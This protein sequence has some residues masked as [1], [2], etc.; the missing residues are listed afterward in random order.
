MA[1]CRVDNPAVALSARFPKDVYPNLKQL[2]GL[3]K[4]SDIVKEYGSRYPELQLEESAETGALGFKSNSFIDTEA[5]FTLEE[6]LAMELKNIKSNAENMAGKGHTVEDAVIT[7]PPFFTAQERQAV[8]TAVELAGFRLLSLLSDGLAVGLNYATSR[9][10]PVVNEGGKPEV[11]LVYD[12]G[13]GSASATVLKFQGKTVKDVGKF[14]K[15]IQEVHVVGSSWDRT[16]GGDSLNR[17][18]LD[19]MLAK[20]T[21]QPATKHLSVTQVQVQGH[22]RTMSKL[23]KEAQRVRQVLSANTE[24]HASFEGLYSEDLNFKYKLSRSEFESLASGHQ[25]RVQAPIQKALDMA[26]LKLEE[27]D[28]VILHGGA[29][30]TPFIQKE[31]EGLVGKGKLRTNVNSD[32]AA[33]L[34]A[35]FRSATISPSFRVKEIRPFDIA[36]YPIVAS[37][38][39]DGK[40]KQQKLFVPT[41]TIGPE[42]QI[43]FKTGKDFAFALSQQVTPGSS[44]VISNFQTQNLT[45]SIKS[46]VSHGCVAS[47]INPKFGIRLSPLNGLPEVVSG[48]VSCETQEPEKK[49]VVDGM[50]DFLGFGSKKD[51]QKPLKADEVESSST[52]TSSS[53][54]SPSES[55]SSSESA[56]SSKAA[57]KPKEPK[58]KAITIPLSISVEPVNAS[59]IKSSNL[60]RIKDRITAFDASDRARDLRAESLNTLE[61][62]TYK[63][64]ETL[65]ED[66]FILAST[67]SQR[68]E[69]SKSSGATSAWLYEDG[70]DAPQDVLKEK[71]DQLR[72]LVNPIKTRVSEEKN[73]PEALKKLEDSLKQAESMAGVIRSMLNESTASISFASEASA[74]EAASSSAAASSSETTSST[75]KDDFEDL[76]E[77]S[78]SSPATS[79]TTSTPEP[80]PPLF[81]ENDL[82]LVEDKREDVQ[83]WLN[84]K[85]AKQQKLG[86]TDDPVLL[87]SDL[88]TKA[89]ELDGLAETLV[90]KISAPKPKKSKPSSKNA[91]RTSASES[92]T[93]TSTEST[94]PSTSIQT[95]SSESPEPSATSATEAEPSPA[96]AAEPSDTYVEAFQEGIVPDQDDLSAEEQ[97]RILEEQARIDEEL[98]AEQSS[99]IAKAKASESK[100]N[101]KPKSTTKAKGKPKSKSKAKSTSS[102]T[103]IKSKQKSKDKGHSEL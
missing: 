78:T 30:R 77:S 56:A 24:A 95:S 38:T 53:S 39:V 6:L 29:I 88:K 97:M 84:E 22:G 48:S 11:H 82:N 54:S 31:L 34:G 75:S 43:S 68:D 4:E 14:N 60:Q 96:Q 92:N 42:K 9:T 44:V 25:R 99:I 100:K 62:Y 102:K 94:S 50:K 89:K 59:S 17:L 81:T 49:G 47:D 55:P 26:K 51:D 36:L 58:K 83:K 90:R 76:D 5:S 41:S 65:L 20:F 57:D 28:S 63:L 86:P 7:V 23:L 67:E 2:L 15:T 3:S 74:S 33:V 35:G 12:I 91:R 16:L 80:L 19:D 72:G 46:L 73:R 32:E 93:S 40:E 1:E 21:N 18:V 8:M 87:S 79:A 85:L 98:A 37:W 101:K 13:A 27:I 66:G 61:S 45:E 10:F 52:I 103:K 69:I 70:A 71:L 64:R